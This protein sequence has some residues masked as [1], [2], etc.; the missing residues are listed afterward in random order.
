MSKTNLTLVLF[1][2]FAAA[3]TAQTTSITYQGSLSNSGNPANGNYDFQFA[4]YPTA[5]IG[6]PVLEEVAV[7][8]VPVTNGTFSV[9]LSFSNQFPGDPRFL[10][11]RVRP[12]GI[13]THTTLTPRSRITSSPYSVRSLNSSNADAL[14]GTPASQFVLNGDSRLTDARNP[15]PSSAS[16]IQNR[17]TPQVGSANFNIS[18]NGMIGGSLIAKENSLFE[19]AVAVGTTLEVGTTATVGSTLSVGSNANIGGAIN[20]GTQ[21]N[22]AG[23][24]VLNRSRHDLF[25][26]D[27]M[28]RGFSFEVMNTS[29]HFLVLK[30]DVGTPLITFALDGKVGIGDNNPSEATLEVGGTLAVSNLGGADGDHLCRNGNLIRACSAALVKKDAS[31]IESSATRITALEAT[32]RIQQIEIERQRTELAALKNFICLQNP[33]AGICRLK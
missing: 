12:A 27:A 32:I 18:G 11:I 6:S 20:T 28:S 22:V 1:V 5:A 21:Y 10:E 23:N 7:N 15:L 3:A 24:F 25:S 19:R 29:P 16:Y 30:N 17:T 13:G 14:G 4:L 26:T 31:A 9:L 33:A 8:N 2:V